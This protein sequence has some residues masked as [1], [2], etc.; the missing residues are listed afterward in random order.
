MVGGNQ[1]HTARAGGRVRRV[2]RADSADRGQRHRQAQEAARGGL[3]LASRNGTK[4]RAHRVERC[5]LCRLLRSSLAGRQRDE[6]QLHAAVLLAAR[7]RVVGRDGA[8]LALADRDDAVRPD[9][10]R[11]EIGRDGAGAAIRQLLVVRVAADTVRVARHLD[12]RLIELVDDQADGIENFEEV[13][14]QIGAVRRKSDVSRHVQRDVVTD[15]RNADAR[16]FE[17]GAELGFLAILVGAD[18]GCRPG[19]RAPRLRGR[20]FFAPSSYRP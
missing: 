9:A 15:A 11:A 7:V 10:A 3:T 2:G 12:D 5:A 14:V 20:A 1:G 6:R 16:A 19:P 13:R 18:T 17:L 4:K 8:A